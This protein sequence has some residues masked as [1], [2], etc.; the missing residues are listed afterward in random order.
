MTNKREKIKETET[1]EQDAQPE[2]T[3]S[4]NVEQP[5]IEPV[6]LFEFEDVIIFRHPTNN[7][8][9]ID[10]VRGGISDSTFAR[11]AVGPQKFWRLTNTGTGS[12]VNVSEQKGNRSFHFVGVLEPGL[13]DLTVGPEVRD[14]S[15]HRIPGRGYK[16]T[17]R[18]L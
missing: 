11:V 3:E 16:I 6:L 13:Y 7:L 4:T 8:V 15:K 5:T 17:F 14:Y 1:N 12:Q 18:I 2:L 9:T 10:K